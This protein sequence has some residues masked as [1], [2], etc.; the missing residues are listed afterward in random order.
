LPTPAPLLNYG[1][2]LVFTGN[3]TCATETENCASWQPVVWV[4][5]EI[6]ACMNVHINLCDSLETFSPVWGYLEATCPCSQFIGDDDDSFSFYDCPCG[7]NASMTWLALLP[8]TYYYPLFSNPESDPPATL[9]DYII[10]VIAG[11]PCGDPPVNDEC[12]DALEVF[13]NTTTAYST[14]IADTE[15]DPYLGDC[16]TGAPT[17]PEENCGPERD[18][19]F[20]YR[21]AQVGSNPVC[22]DLCGAPIE[23]YDPMLAVYGPWL[24][25]PSTVC[26][27]PP[28]GLEPYELGCD[29]DFCG[30]PGYG[31]PGRVEIT[32]DRNKWYLIRVG[33]CAGSWGTGELGVNILGVGE[34]CGDPLGKCCYLDS[35]GAVQCVESTEQGCYDNVD[36]L[37]TAGL[38]CP[39]TPENDCPPAG[40]CC[41]L[42]GGVVVCVSNFESQCSALAGEWDSGLDCSG[43]PP[44][45]PFGRCCWNAG[46][47]AVCTE[48]SEA[49]CLSLYGSTY[50]DEGLNCTDDPCPVGRCCHDAGCDVTT[51]VVCVQ[52]Y[53]GVWDAG[54]NCGG[55]P[56]C[57]P[58]GACC[59]ELY[60]YHCTVTTE[61]DC[62][63][64]SCWFEGE[65]CVDPTAYCP[66]VPCP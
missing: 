22:F 9:G 64:A 26:P 15:Y 44:C 49:V 8:G 27:P 10:T 33:G 66:A 32:C 48:T 47:I 59:G 54:L 63:D 34:V 18:I 65:D 40:R 12:P 42:Q 35:D 61:A 4:S 31:P 52:N 11:E 25:D 37:W 38:D 62:H 3:N 55:S 20:K 14:A 36:G 57:P 19:F 53:S 6:V 39:G 21:H 2:Q 56:P 7:V 1:E 29:D 45:P 41:Y 16:G 60:I 13:A 24:V 28:D 23:S 17:P 58:L 5:F 30:T 51:E 43:T 46:G 50:W